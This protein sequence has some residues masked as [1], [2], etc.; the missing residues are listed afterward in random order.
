MPI[1]HIKQPEIIS[2]KHNLRL[3]KY[4]GNI[5]FA[6]EW[7]QD[8]D[9]IYLVDGNREPYTLERLK[10]MYEY[11]DKKGELYFIEV[12]EKEGYRPVGD[13]TFCREDMPIVIGCKEYRGRGIGRDVI[14]ALIARAK[15][16]G[17]AEIF[18]DSDDSG[19]DRVVPARRVVVRVY[20][21]SGDGTGFSHGASVSVETAGYGNRVE[22]HC[23]FQGGTLRFYRFGQFG[24]Y[25][26]ARSLDRS[27]Q[28]GFRHHE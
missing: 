6:L 20:D 26:D 14:A 11:L 10:A 23:P 1:L 15:E 16:L 8:L 25:R 19:S 12:L 22:P 4:D 21:S 27:E 28:R 2:V 3:R 17:Y 9:T 5:M 24:G 7:Y 18:V 13:V